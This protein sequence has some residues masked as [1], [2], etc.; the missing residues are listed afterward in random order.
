MAR[1]DGLCK[2]QQLDVHNGKGEVEGA[3]RLEVEGVEGGLNA[4]LELAGRFRNHRDE[5]GGESG[6]MAE[7]KVIE[8][9]RCPTQAPAPCSGWVARCSMVMKSRRRCSR[10]ASD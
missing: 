7:N 4:V 8:P 9:R 3:Q 1:R 10:P 5:I 2:L 6:R